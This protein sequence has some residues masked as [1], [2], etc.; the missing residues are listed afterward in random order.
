MVRHAYLW[1]VIGN[2]TRVAR[3]SGSSRVRHSVER[4]EG[5]GKL[6]QY[7]SGCGRGDFSFFLALPH[8][9]RDL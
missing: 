5:K 1:A 2:K 8:N 9:A 4:I 7:E 3:T 6:P